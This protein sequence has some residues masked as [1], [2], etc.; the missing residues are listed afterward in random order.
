MTPRM[1][2]VTWHQAAAVP[3][4]KNPW[5]FRLGTEAPQSCSGPGRV[6]A[7]HRTGLPGSQAD[8]RQDGPANPVTAVDPLLHRVYKSNCIARACTGTHGVQ[9]AP[10]A[11]GLGHPRGSGTDSPRTRAQ[12]HC[13]EPFYKITRGYAEGT[14]VGPETHARDALSPRGSYSG[15]DNASAT[16]DAGGTWPSLGLRRLPQRET[17]SFQVVGAASLCDDERY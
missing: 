10:V 3:T 9:G 1:E 15:A 4:G 16:A 6:D 2:L 17:P 11:L 12:L 7:S 8:S 13:S 14:N 5:K